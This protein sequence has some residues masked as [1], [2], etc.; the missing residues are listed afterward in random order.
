MNWHAR[1]LN[2]IVIFGFP[3]AFF[4]GDQ[5]ML[6]IY[7]ASIWFYNHRMRKLDA[8]FGIENE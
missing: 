2:E 4:M 6:V 8:Q 5:G 1:S 3:L 7:L